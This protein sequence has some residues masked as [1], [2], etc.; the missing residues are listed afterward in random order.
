[1]IKPITTASAAGQDIF[2]FQQ[3]IFNS[4]A[5]VRRD[6]APQPFGESLA[7]LLPGI[8]EAEA[9]PTDDMPKLAV[10][11]MPEVAV[12]KGDMLVVNREGKGSLMM[13]APAV[14]AKSQKLGQINQ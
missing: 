4:D 14:L 8:E 2:W 3:I 9:A 1:M 7:G 11:G 5:A 10:A 13:D 12:G 6:G